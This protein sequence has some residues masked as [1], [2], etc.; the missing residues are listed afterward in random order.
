MEFKTLPLSPVR[1]GNLSLRFSIQSGFR[2]RRE[3]MRQMLLRLNRKVLPMATLD[4]LIT[5]TRIRD[6][7]NAPT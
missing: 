6:F 2:E 7:V 1:I 4:P 5:H 3:D